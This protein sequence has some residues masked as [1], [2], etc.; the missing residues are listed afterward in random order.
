M[1]DENA[2]SDDRLEAAKT[3]CVA[4]ANIFKLVN[5]GP[6]FKPTLPIYPNQ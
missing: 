3:L 6:T 5:D 2:K 1:N 4:E